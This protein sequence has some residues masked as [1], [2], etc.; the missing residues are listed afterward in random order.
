VQRAIKWLEDKN[1]VKRE[2]KARVGL[3]G[4][5]SPLI[6]TDALL[7][8]LQLKGVQGKP[9]R[10]AKETS[11]VQADCSISV[12][13]KSTV[14][15]R[16]QPES[17]FSRIDGFAIPTE[18]AW[19]C[20]ENELKPT[21][22]LSLMKLAKQAKQRLANVLTIAHEYVCDLRGRELYA[23]LR[24]VIKSGKDFN[25][26]AKANNVEHTAAQLRERLMLK[27]HELA[28]RCYYNPDK[29]LT[30][31]VAPPGMLTEV[32]NGRTAI[33]PINEAFLLAIEDGRLVAQS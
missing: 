11:P 6:P 12:G 23:Y 17:G 27:S 5:S 29:A 25:Y 1:L 33:G 22:L 21:A 9:Q 4:S 19:L 2:Q 20:A 32:R 18:L 26:M 16:K 8:A 31:T 14:L 30:V 28:G 3:R 24:E 13:L 7:T 15:I 10:S